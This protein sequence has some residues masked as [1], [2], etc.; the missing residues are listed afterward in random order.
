MARDARRKGASRDLPAASP[1][2]GSRSKSA[3]R[4]R[5]QNCTQRVFEEAAQYLPKDC[6]R[7]M[8]PSFSPF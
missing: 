2:D 1:G 8:P 6:S 3:M 5:G 7:K 4:L